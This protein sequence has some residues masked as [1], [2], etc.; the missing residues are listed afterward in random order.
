MEAKVISLFAFALLL[1]ACG[2]KQEA[3]VAS[4]PTVQVTSVTQNTIRRIVRGDGILFPLEQANV[5]PKITAP[6]SKF[7]VHRGDH[8]REGQ[9]VAELENK[10]LVGAAKEAKTA[11]DVAESNLRATEGSTIPEAVVKAQTDL[12]AARQ[13]RASSKKVLD[14]FGK[15]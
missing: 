6:V 12:E 5:V 14:S 13:A 10:D 9:L 7:Y 3:E 15:L 1:S 11:I 2:K 8:V 4:P